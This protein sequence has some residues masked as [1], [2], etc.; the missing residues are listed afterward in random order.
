MTSSKHSPSYTNM[1]YDKC[2]KTL[3]GLG[4]FGIKPGLKTIRHLLKQLGSPEQKFKSIHIA[5]TNGKG[6]TASNIASI[7]TASGIKTGLF[8]SPHLIRFNERISVNGLQI[9]DPEVVEFYK[10]VKQADTEEQSATFFEYATAMA[11]CFF[12]EKGIEYAV[13]ETGMGG[14]LDAT[15]IITPRVSVITTISMDHES[16]LGNTIEEIAADKSGIIKHQTPV[17]TGV[18]NHEALKII[19]T[20]ADGNNSDLLKIDSDFCLVPDKSGS[21]SYSCKNHGAIDNIQISL[22]GDHQIDNAAL[23]IATCAILEDKRITHDSVRNGLNSVSWP[24][25]L[26]YI[27]RNPWIILDGAHNP[28]AAEKLSEYLKTKHKNKKICV[29]VGMMKDKDIA[30]SLLPIAGVSSRVIVTES[31]SPRAEKAE[32][33]GNFFKKHFGITPHVIPDLPAAIN[34]ALSSGRSD[35]LVCITGSLYIAGEAKAF[36]EK[37]K[38]QT[39]PN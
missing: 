37:K 32:V 22:N 27:S 28:D 14:Q 19:E 2:I 10:K 6:S 33:L 23:S 30:G 35:E 1:S 16:F 26:E 29:I 39:A 13:T 31:K 25:R 9:A 12:A 3:F 15:N 20:A 38:F 5:G 8:T 34:Y 18:R 21:Y 24:G 7:L 17:I 4:R 36:F 11:F